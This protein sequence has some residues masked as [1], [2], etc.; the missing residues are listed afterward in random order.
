MDICGIC[1]REARLTERESYG[2]HH[3]FECALCDGQFWVPMENPGKEWYER[4]ERSTDRIINP[5]KK[6]ER[7]HREFLRDLPAPKGSLLDVGMGTGNFLAAA[8]AKGYDGYG[9]DFD[10]GSLRVARDIFGLSKAYS[11]DLE[12]LREKMNG[13]K[14]DVI[15]LFEVL[16]HMGDLPRFMD[17]VKKLLSPSGFLAISVPCRQFADFLK[18]NDKPPRHLSRWNV[19]ALQNFLGIHGFAVERMKIIRVTIPYLITKFHLTYGAWTSINLVRRIAASSDAS[20][21]ASKNGVRKIAY[22]ARLARVKDYILFFVPALFLYLGLI[23][24]GKSG[25]GLYVLSRRKSH[26]K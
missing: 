12:E 17:D 24:T 21:R 20:S 3:L 23:V 6:P 16:E 4:D 19:R 11:I 2:I 22:A 1:K 14:F 18:P 5:L 8:V 25:L 9:I 13:R 26:E 15:T 7:N 10:E